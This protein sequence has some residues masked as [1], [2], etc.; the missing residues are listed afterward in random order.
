M[1]KPLHTCCVVDREGGALARPDRLGR[2]SQPPTI[3]AAALVAEIEAE[4]ARRRSAGAYPLELLRRLHSEFSVDDE[5]E[6]PEALVV[7]SA[8]RPLRSDRL[9]G[10]AIV[11]GK[12]VVRRCLAWYIQ[13]FADDQTRFNTAILRDLRRLE[14]R[15]ERVETPWGPTA[16]LTPDPTWTADAKGRAAVVATAISGAPTGPLALVGDVGDDLLDRLRDA[17][18]AT[19]IPPSAG[20]PLRYLESL[21]AHSLAG[22][23]LAGVLPRLSAAELVALLPTAARALVPAGVLIADAPD[24]RRLRQP[25]DPSQA[26]VG[27]QR[28]LDPATIVVLAEAAGLM[29]PTVIPMGKSPHWYAVTATRPSA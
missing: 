27:M 17:G 12:K 22:V 26:M 6:P 11:V 4:V 2:V 21:P 1:I 3:D 29:S 19:R 13:P 16:A 18:R 23:V 28:W 24:P 25:T 9:L 20:D 14:R 7:V 8:S 5:P 15:V 10:Q